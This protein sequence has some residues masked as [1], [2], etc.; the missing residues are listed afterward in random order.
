MFSLPLP[1]FKPITEA[2]SDRFTHTAFS[3]C[4]LLLPSSLDNNAIILTD[5]GCVSAYEVVG[6][7][8]YLT[9]ETELNY[10][11]DVSDN[12]RSLLRTNH[13]RISIN[14]VRDQNRTMTVLDDIYLPTQDSITRLGIDAQHFFEAQKEDLS[15]H[16]A[17]ERTL[18]VITT[19]PTATKR[20]DAENSAPT[21]NNE[22]INI[23]FIEKDAPNPLLESSDILQTH[24][25]YC[26]Q[27]VNNL[28]SLLTMKA[29]TA[30]EYIL[31]LKEEE[32]LTPLNQTGWRAKK[33]GDD[34]DL[35]FNNTDED[36]ITYP[37]LAY[38]IVTNDK[39]KMP[40]DPSIIMSNEHYI[41]T[42]DREYFPI[43][44]TP[45]SKV[46]SNI[47]AHIPLRMSFDLDTGTED[48]VTSLNNRKS[49]LLFFLASKKSR[50][51]DNA[52]EQL[53]AYAEK[54]NGTLLSGHLSVSTWSKDLMK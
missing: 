47:P 34:I 36:F 50:T 46:I 38:Q 27:L 54:D 42:I 25:S 13:H 29:L 20:Q 32:E 21:I 18:M 10:I 41:A 4:Q 33:A 23:E 5:G 26:K 24:L 14:Y 3:H 2:L 52:L 11:D 22:T 28:S 44:P 43:D 37:P 48:I 8:R 53:I 12:M 1:S 35:V 7:N 39:D 40:R 45:F 30:D 6:V 19:K 51:I 31:A 9:K 16:C 17:Y 15:K 49:W